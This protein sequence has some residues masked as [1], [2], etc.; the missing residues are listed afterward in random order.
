M[1]GRQDPRTSMLA[2][3]AFVDVE[4]C[5]PLEHPLRTIKRLTDEALASLRVVLATDRPGLLSDEHF[6]VDGTLIEAAA[7]P[8]TERSL[9]G[10]SATR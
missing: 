8:A 9:A 7:G 6:T 3:V 1:R 2:F 10:G 5:V 4:P